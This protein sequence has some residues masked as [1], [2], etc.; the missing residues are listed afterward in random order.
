MES[1]SLGEPST[2]TLSNPIN[3]SLR[4]LL[5][6]STP[7]IKVNSTSRFGTPAF[8]LGPSFRISLYDGRGPVARFVAFP[9][10]LDTNAFLVEEQAQAVLFDEQ[11]PGHYTMSVELG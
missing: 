5:S 4:Q 1:G 10:E 3:H 8:L 11:W 7:L 9:G 2:S 6:L